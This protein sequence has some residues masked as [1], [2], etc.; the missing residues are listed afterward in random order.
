MI[1]GFAVL[2]LV[3]KLSEQLGTLLVASLLSIKLITHL[4]FFHTNKD[5]RTA[6]HKVLDI[7]LVDL[8]FVDLAQHL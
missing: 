5:L 7:D 4:L 6:V 3:N 8:I 1:V 2:D